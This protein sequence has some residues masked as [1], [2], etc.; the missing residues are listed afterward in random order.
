MLFLVAF[1]GIALMRVS[2]LLPF[3]ERTWM[4]DPKADPAQRAQ[5]LLAKMTEKEKVHYLH[6]S[7]SG[8][9]GNVEANSRLGIPALK[10]NDGPQGFRDNAHEGTTTSWPCALCIGASWDTQL[11][12]K[13]GSAMGIEFY[14][15]GANVQL[16]PGMCIARVP[17]NGR[18]FE[19]ISGEDP[20]LGYTMVQPVIKG[21]QSR[22]VVANAKHYVN[23]NQETHR[24]TVSSVVDER[25]EFEIYLPPFEGAVVA[26]V[27]SVMCSYNKING[28]WACENN[29][30]LG[31]LKDDLGF[32]GW[33]MSDWGATHSSSVNQGLDQEM[34][35]SA[36]MG[37]KQLQDMLANNK[38]TIDKINDSVLRILTP[39]FA[40]GVFDNPTQGTL[41]A[42]VT[43][44]AHNTLARELAAAG[45]VLVKNDDNTLPLKK[46][47]GLKVA[48]IGPQA[49]NPVVHGGGS[50]QVVPYYTSSPLD[51]VREKL[52]LAPLTPGTANCSDAHWV[53]D[54]DFFNT[55]SQ[56]SKSAKDI[57][58]CCELCADRIGCNAF[59]L[60]DG[61]CWMKGDAKNPTHHEGITSGM[62]TRTSGPGNAECDPTGAYC[63][64]YAQ[65]GDEASQAAAK[66]DVALVFAYTTSSEGGDRGSLSL[67][68]GGDDLISL[69]AKANPNTVAVVV[70]PGALLTPWSDAVKSVLVNFMPG[71]EY[72]HA[73]A[74]V[75]FGDV[76]PS[77]KLPLTFPNIENEVQFTDAMWPGVDLVSTYS[78]KL[79]VGY[80][81]YDAHQVIPKFAFGHG[82]SYTSFTYRGLKG[83]KDSFQVSITNS[84][85]VAGSEVVQLYL[86]FPS[87]AGEPP[88]QLKGM[89]KV[90]IPAGSSRDVSF[91]MN[92]RSYSTW[93][94]SSHGWKVAHGDFKVHVGSSSRD[95]RVSTTVTV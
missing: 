28:V 14:Q 23:N 12:N 89:Q 45:A 63:V 72:G 70:T 44:V 17:R 29:V 21:I 85:K 50:G 68:D 51:A 42:N 73:V 92:D 20:F 18:N 52:G 48:V 9:I 82:L 3:P 64:Y 93:D 54:T 16:G 46:G 8:Y 35:G 2:A 77:G 69:V 81:W 15:K 91:A 24:T 58:A 57:T 78:E 67:N 4:H 60:A 40:V 7:G 56:T 1:I 66:A 49:A 43:S 83:D 6:G 5:E 61:T 41:D 39:L 71:Q 33:V 87:S 86:E 30:T 10:L 38:T 31:Y 47:S 34:P 36:F 88:M 55:D 25:T 65:G 13:W 26:D 37:D 90:S 84:G 32:K 74:D 22:G 27:G 80:R 53:Q 62:I 94:V 95:I 79:E 59:S 11:A 76:N 19:Y 75:L